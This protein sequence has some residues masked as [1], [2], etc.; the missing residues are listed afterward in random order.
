MSRRIALTAVA[1]I[2]GFAVGTVGCAPASPN[3][4]P[5]G[6]PPDPPQ[7]G[8]SCIGDLDGALTAL[9]KPADDLSN[10]RNL[11]QCSNGTWEPF[12]DPYPSSD[13]WLS[14]GPAVVL[15]GQGRRNPEVKAGVWTATPVTAEAQCSAER[16]DVVSAGRTSAPETFSADPGQP[17]TLDVSDHLFTVAFSGYCL[18]QRS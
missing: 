12:L 8:A 9:P 11:L 5:P 14:T 6:P 13:R 1:A 15:H 7:A 10:K 17:L 3:P 2:A 16:V 18:W 4:P